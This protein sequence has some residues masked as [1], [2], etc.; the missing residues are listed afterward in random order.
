ME[1][2][3]AQQL[4]ALAMIAE[5]SDKLIPAMSGIVDELLGNMQDDTLAL[6]GQIIDGL[7]FV[8]ETYNVTTEIVG[9]VVEKDTFEEVIGRLSKAMMSEDY[10]AAAVVMRDDILSFLKDYGEAAKKAVA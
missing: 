2:Y 7:N 9:D 5:Y 10:K 1:D 8:I 4:D 6:L 3:R